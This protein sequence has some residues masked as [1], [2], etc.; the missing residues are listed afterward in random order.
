MTFDDFSHLSNNLLLHLIDKKFWHFTFKLKALLF[1]KITRSHMKKEKRSAWVM[2]I[3]LLLNT[4][5]EIRLRRMFILKKPYK[6]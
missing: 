4:W 3:I 1:K 6:Q 2:A 5:L